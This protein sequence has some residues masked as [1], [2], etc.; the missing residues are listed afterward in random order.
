M[1][2][3]FSK[4]K[5]ATVSLFPVQSVSHVKNSSQDSSA[6]ENKTSKRRVHFGANGAYE[7][8][9]EE[10]EHPEIGSTQDEEVAAQPAENIEEEKENVVAEDV[11]K[12]DAVATETMEE[13]PPRVRDEEKAKAKKK[14]RSSSIGKRKVTRRVAAKFCT[15]V[16]KDLTDSERIMSLLTLVA[17]HQKNTYLSKDQ[18]HLDACKFYCFF[19]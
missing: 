6:L 16:P 5:Q 14:K 11:A 13:S 15:K 4:R 7:L 18:V 9:S 3:L 12:P 1:H 19:F 8:T 10:C 2:K 17:E